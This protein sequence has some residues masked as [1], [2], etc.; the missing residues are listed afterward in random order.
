MPMS[1]EASRSCAVA[2]MSLP[3][4]DQRMNANSAAVAATAI[5]NATI[6]ATL[7]AAPKSRT[8]AA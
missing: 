6:C 7:N 4:Y 2:R 8:I 1:D 3:V 5:A